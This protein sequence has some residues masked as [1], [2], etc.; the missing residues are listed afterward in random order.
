M[1]ELEI[2]VVDAV[3]RQRIRLAGCLRAARFEVDV[4]DSFAIA[5]N[6]ISSRKPR[7]VIAGVKLGAYNGLQLISQAQYVNPS[8]A[9]VLTHDSEDLVLEREAR[10]MNTEFLVLPCSENHIV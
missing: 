5:R 1:N 6:K 2:L 10:L 7:C 3:E 8:V 4:A 9:S